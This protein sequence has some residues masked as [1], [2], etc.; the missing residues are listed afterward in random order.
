MLPRTGVSA[1]LLL[2]TSKAW[3]VC[4]AGVDPANLP[5]EVMLMNGSASYGV[6]AV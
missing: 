3:C 4:E 5:D 6:D 2:G 1:C